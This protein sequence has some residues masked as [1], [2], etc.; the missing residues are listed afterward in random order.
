MAKRR[1]LKKTVL[2]LDGIVMACLLGVTAFI[3]FAEV[4]VRF[5]FHAPLAHVAEAV[6]NLFVWMTFL[7]V[8]VAEK[9][10]AHL[11]ISLFASA[12]LRLRRV[13]MAFRR[14]GTALFFLI[15]GL[16]GLRM[17]YGSLMR[18]EM[19]PFGLPASLFS[20]AVPVGSLLILYRLAVSPILRGRP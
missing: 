4:A 10:G 16:Y 17:S 1:T 12:P 20:L 5:V 7:G 18:G 3:T 11:G 2:D 15:V 14:A 19:T 9:K 6:P 8:A 13:L